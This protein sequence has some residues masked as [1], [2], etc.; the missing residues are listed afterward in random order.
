[1]MKV[2]DIIDRFPDEIVRYEG[3]TGF[4][5]LT[6]LSFGDAT[7]NSCPAALTWLSDKK[8]AEC[9]GFTVDVGLLIVSAEA[10][11]QVKNTGACTIIAKQPRRLFQAVLSHWFA[12]R[13]EPRTESSAFIDP[14]VT[15]GKDCYFGHN[16]VIEAGCSL[17][18]HCEIL[19]N[20]V[21]LKGT[22]I[23]NE[24]RIGSNC[25]I[26]NYGFG[27][28]KNAEGDY[29]LIEHIGNVIIGDRVE[30]HNNTCIDRAVM[31][32]TRIG[33][34]VKIDNMVHIA[35]GVTL[36]ENCLVI[37]HAMVA[38]S[39]RVG[40]NTWISP[41]ALIKNQLRVGSNAMVGMGA[42]VLK[43]VKEGETVIGNPSENIASYRN[44]SAIRRILTE[45]KGKKED[46]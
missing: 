5:I 7:G 39:A 8:A 12:I 36:E 3:E 14:S 20:T 2:R 19:H 11:G 46:E 30:I 29:T 37:A 4:E 28:E 26:G 16:V 35:H 23:G 6:A 21:I 34:N 42:V 45:E 10:Y 32:S 40:R 1:M 33:R 15:I 13:R 27:Y 24:V 43:E 31:G 44:W 25:T 18:D 17:G 38:G 9:T 41:G 22:V